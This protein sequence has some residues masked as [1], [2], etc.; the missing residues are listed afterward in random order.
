MAFSLVDLRVQRTNVLR[1]C[2]QENRPDS[3]YLKD[4]VES[5]T[6]DGLSVAG[7]FEVSIAERAQY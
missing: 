7:C 1:V 3:K 4:S 2:S 6:V 5:S